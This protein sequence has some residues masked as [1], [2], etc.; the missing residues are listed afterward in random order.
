MSVSVIIASYN[1]YEQ[2]LNTIESIINQTYKNIEIIIVNDY[3]SDNRYFY[4]DKVINENYIKEENNLD[5]VKNYKIKIIN[6]DKNTCSR[7]K[8]GFPSCGYVRNQGFK[9][10]NGKYIAIVDDDD[11]WLPNKIENQIKQMELYEGKILGCCTEAY[12]SDIKPNFINSS[13]KYKKYNTEYYHKALSKKYGFDTNILFP[14]FITK[15]EIDKHNIIICSSMLFSKEVFNLIGYM[16]EVE[17]WKGT[18]GI[19]QDWNYWKKMCNLNTK[20]NKI[21]YLKEP[22]LIYYKKN[23]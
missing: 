19:Y 18:N 17:N 14:S 4:L 1:R 8:L 12:I 5:G 2:L 11:Y 6:L 21:L 23:L 3:S 16:P 7:S 13:N 20:N 10:A 15:K 22:L 9:I